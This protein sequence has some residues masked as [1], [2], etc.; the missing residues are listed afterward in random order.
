MK[1][2]DK[3]EWINIFSV[4]KLYGNRTAYGAVLQNKGQV[5]YIYGVENNITL[6]RSEL[7]SI[8]RAVEYLPTG[9]YDVVIYTKSQYI[10]DS[11]NKNIMFTWFNNGGYK[12]DGSLVKNMDLWRILV[13]HIHRF[14]RVYCRKVK[15][16]PKYQEVNKFKEWYYKHYIGSRDY[17]EKQAFF[18]FKYMQ[19]AIK[20]ADTTVFRF[21]CPF[22]VVTK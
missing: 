7:L 19:E 10:V 14:R 4:A 2:K 16:S 17:T 22:E 13:S 20:L 15:I 21:R 11:I 12:S 8:V 6:P 1:Q 5:Q 3:P 9:E 18:L